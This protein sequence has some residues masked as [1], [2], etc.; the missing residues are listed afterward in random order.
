[1]SNFQRVSTKEGHF[2]GLYLY[3]LCFPLK[4]RT[5]IK[6]E[7]VNLGQVQNTSQKRNKIHKSKCRIAG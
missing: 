6:S 7:E 4:K 3:A 1:M 2:I 5:E